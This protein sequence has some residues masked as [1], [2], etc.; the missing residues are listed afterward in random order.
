MTTEQVREV[1]NRQG[2][3]NLRVTDG[4][5]SKHVHQYFLLYWQIPSQTSDLGVQAQ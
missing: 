3:G 1:D 4:V 2:S 5:F